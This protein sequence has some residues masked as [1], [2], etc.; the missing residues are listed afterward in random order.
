VYKGLI[1]VKEYVDPMH[2]CTEV[3]VAVPR[4]V[5]APL[6]FV[7][8]S[9]AAAAAGLTTAFAAAGGE[10]FLFAGGVFLFGGGGGGDDA[11]FPF[12][13]AP[14][15]TGVCCLLF[16]FAEAADSSSAVGFL[17]AANRMPRRFFLISQGKLTSRYSSLCLRSFPSSRP[18]TN[19][20][21]QFSYKNT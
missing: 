9:T 11:V 7:F 13:V 10:K 18:N 4:P 16:V 3:V 5:L 21:G 17:S 19:F 2:S 15:K 1:R 12:S 8:F 6:V 14:S 20:F